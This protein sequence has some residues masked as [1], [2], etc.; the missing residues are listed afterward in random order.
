RGLCTHFAGAESISNYVRIHEQKKKYRKG[1]AWFRQHGLSPEYR[2]TCCSAAAIRYPEMRFD[3]VRL[4]ILQYGLWPSREIFIEF[5][6]HRPSSYE[7]PVKR[8]I[9]WKS[10]VMS[11]K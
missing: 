4:G 10:Q 9:S 5:L 3:L 7:S 8:L 6:K 11:L 1:L 2:H